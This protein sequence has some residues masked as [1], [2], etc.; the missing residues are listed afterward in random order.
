M[1]TIK[2]ID[3]QFYYELGKQIRRV[4]E[5]LDITQKKLANIVGCSRSLIVAYE[6]GYTKI[7]PSKWNKICEALDIRS[8]IEISVKI[9]QKNVGYD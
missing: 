3:E 5:R 7:K 4:R 1:Q 6:N 9:D 2:T 8:G